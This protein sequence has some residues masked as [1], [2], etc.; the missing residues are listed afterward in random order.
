[1]NEHFMI[2]HH[3]HN[4]APVNINSF[5]PD[6]PFKALN[7]GGV[8]HIVR[9]DAILRKVREVIDAHLAANPMPM[10]VSMGEVA[11]A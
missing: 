6:H 9:D 1:M 8:T 7:I 2:H 5:G 10:S 4:D 3:I 11:A